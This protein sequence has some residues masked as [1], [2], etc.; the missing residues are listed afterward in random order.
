LKISDYSENELVG[1]LKRG[2]LLLDL[3]PFVVR[4]CSDIADMAHDISLMYADFYTRP[5]ESFS[6]FHVSV[7][8][9]SGVFNWIKPR[10]RFFFDGRPSFIP[11]PESQAFAML[12]WGLN[13]CVA[14]HSHHYLII[15]AAVVERGGRAALLPGQP[16]AGKSTLCAGLINRGWRLLSDE[17][18]LFDM[19]NSL[20]FGM[21]RPV[22]LKNASINVIKQFAPETVMTL[23]VSDTTKGTVALMRPPR[24][25]V[26]LASCG[27][28]PAWIVLPNYSAGSQPI[29]KEQGRAETFMLIAEQAFNYDIHGAKGFMAV[30]D[31]VGRSQCHRL[32]YSHLDD[33]ILAFDELHSGSER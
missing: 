12:E 4:I 30:G 33:A 9:E 24:D 5:V 18:A 23:P 8:R 3:K 31:L 16:G 25:S 26:Q 22:N 2:D 6:D 11:L 29:M 17:L 20:L 15:H 14:A 19:E 32:T 13:W 27:A 28:R 21:S 1:L 10:A 7:M